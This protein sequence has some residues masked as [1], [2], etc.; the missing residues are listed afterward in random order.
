[1]MEEGCE[2]HTNGS[3]L[4]QQK[5]KKKDTVKEGNILLAITG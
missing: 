2:I 3:V 4:L 5:K 1:M